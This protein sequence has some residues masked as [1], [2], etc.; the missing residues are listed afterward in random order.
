M[1]RWQHRLWQ[2]CRGIGQR[3]LTIWLAVTLVFGLLRLLP[4]LP[5]ADELTQ[6]GLSAERQ[7]Q[8]W[9]AAG[10]DQPLLTQYLRYLAGIMRGDVGVSLARGIPVSELLA[11]GFQST[12]EIAL[13][14]L[15]I[16]VIGGTGIGIAAS[17]VSS[18]AGRWIGQGVINLAVSLP[19]YWTGTLAILVFSV[20]LDWLP[21]SG[22][23]NLAALVLPIMVLAFH[24]AGSIGRVTQGALDETLTM[25]FIR[26]ARAKGLPEPLILRRHL[27]RVGLLT[28][29]PVLALQT[30]FLLGGTVVTES[31]FARPG[32]GRVL[33]DGVLRRD[34]PVVQ[35]VVLLSVL[36][37]IGL[38]LA[39]DL[40]AS[41]LDPRIR[42]ESQ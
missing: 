33:L 12:L 27:L 17:G 36:M 14:A 5:F 25:A 18:R 35:A 1:A 13:P 9:Q 28:V 30:G 16:A 23:G 2:G 26:T 42:I 32:L 40:T 15:L 3:L 24:T 38:T 11:E 39:A 8:Y 21:A 19:V 37:Y 29:L 31:L 6:A 22:D 4:G 10:L 20:M 41:L 34:Y 7:S